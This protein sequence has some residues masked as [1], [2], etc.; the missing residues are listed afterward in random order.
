MEYSASGERL[1][2][3]AS[4]LF[5][6][7]GIGAIGVDRVAEE[8]GISK[9][10]LYAQFKDKAGLAAAVLQRRRET[11][12]RTI[13]AYLDALPEGEPSKVLAL[14]DFF[15][16]GHAKPGFRGCPFTN[17]AA[18]LPDS[19]HPRPR[20]HQRLQRVDAQPAH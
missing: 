9:P 3:I 14:F 18:E 16:Q 7:E 11:R 17:A 5:Y 13:T 4:Q 1:L 19:T 2:E 10:T 12:E 20:C 6:A 15:I 8:A